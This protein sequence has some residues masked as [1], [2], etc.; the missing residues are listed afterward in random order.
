MKKSIVKV[1]AL[2]LVAVM[3]CLALVSCGAPAKDPA[4]AKAALD[5]N[6]YVA[7]KIDNEGL[8]AIA[9]AVFTAAGIEDLESVVSGTNEDGEHVTIFYFED[10][11]AANE[12]WEDVQKYA[13]DEKDE[14][15]DWVVKKSGNMIYF[16][17]K[18]GVKA[19]K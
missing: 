11:A 17:T 19:A 6:G 4:D 12:Q 15:S 16:G 7:T 3:M 2:S 8:G 1:I 10:S 13:E 14:E 5:E 18:T 9:F